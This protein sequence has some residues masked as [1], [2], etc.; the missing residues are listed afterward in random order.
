MWITIFY[1]RSWSFFILLIKVYYSNISNR[2]PDVSPVHPSL[3]STN[4]SLV[5]VGTRREPISMVVWEAPRF[6]LSLAKT[7]LP[8]LLCAPVFRDLS[9]D[10]DDK[11]SALCEAQ[12]AFIFFFFVNLKRGREGYYYRQLLKKRPIRY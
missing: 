5:W 8:E 4:Y 10:K 2:A 6:G 7:D 12:E 11:A 1:F 9:T 3:Q